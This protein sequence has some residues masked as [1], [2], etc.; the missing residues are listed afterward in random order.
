MATLAKGMCGSKGFYLI[1][2]LRRKCSDSQIGTVVKSRCRMTRTKP[3]ST[4]IELLIVIAI[5]SLLI[6]LSL[7]AVQAAREAARRTA[8][9]NNLRQIGLA[10]HAYHGA[11]KR[12]P[13]ATPFNNY[14]NPA[15][16]DEWNDLGPTWCAAILPHLEEQ[17]IYSQFDFTVPLDSPGN[18]IAVRS[19][20]PTYVCPGD[21]IQNNGVFDERP[22]RSSINP[23]PSLGLWYP[24]SMGPT[25]NDYCP[26]FCP[27]GFPSFC[28]QGYNFGSV[29]EHGKPSPT[30]VGMFGRYALG[31]RFAEVTDGLSKTFM[32]G[33]SLPAQCLQLGAYC[34]N[35]PLAGTTI[36][37]N[38]FADG[39][40]GEHYGKSCG[41]KSRHFG[42]ASFLMGDGSVHFASE[43]IDYEVYN[44]FGTRAGGEEVTLP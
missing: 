43:T 19:Y 37:L 9:Q 29:D 6:L 30:F 24:V 39:T 7:P 31:I 8:C 15:I 3:G 42:G 4:L 2:L 38:T 25:N 32:A 10:L 23:K 34:P 11:H 21:E 26:E 33:E 27:E 5:V 17:A 40:Q 13:Y 20:V 44:E 1:A 16:G 14:K 18:A 41:F 12:L 28:C 22:S 35:F 36:P